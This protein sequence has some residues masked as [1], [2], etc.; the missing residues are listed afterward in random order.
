MTLGAIAAFAV[1]SETSFALSNPAAILLFVVVFSALQ[2][3]LAWGLVSAAVAS[4]YFAIFYS[5]DGQPFRYA[6]AD[7]EDALVWGFAT[8]GIAGMVGLLKRRLER[9]QATQ[10]RI[11]AI[12]I[13]SESFQTTVFQLLETLCESMRWDVGMLWT[14]E[15]GGKHLVNSGIWCRRSL[16]AEAF[17]Q[18]SRERRFAHGE[19]LPGAAWE[20]G[21]PYWIL[22]VTSHPNFPRASDARRAGLHAGVAFPIK[23][24]GELVAVVECFSRHYRGSA[25][26]LLAL[27]ESVGQQI[28]QFLRRKTAEDDLQR[29]LVEQD[30]TIAQ[31]TRDLSIAN[32]QLIGEVA[33]R[34]SVERQLSFSQKQL[35]LIM[36]SI[37]ALI[38]Y[39]DAGLRYVVVNKAYER[40]FDRSADQIIGRH[41][42]EVLGEATYRLVLP[43]VE[44]VL[45]GVAVDYEM[46]IPYLD[47][48]TRHVVVSYVPDVEQDGKVRGFMTLVTDISAVKKARDAARFLADASKALASSLDYGQTLANVAQLA[49]PSF[50][51][52]CVVHLPDADGRL[53]QIAAAHVDPAKV[54]LVRELDH[55]FPLRQ[56]APHGAAHVYRTGRSDLVRAIVPSQFQKHCASQESW[57]LLSTLGLQSYICAPLAIDDRILGT[58]TFAWAQDLRSYDD[59]DLAAAEELAR[60]AALAIEHARVYK[61]LEAANRAKDAW[62]AAVSH[63]LRTPMNVI[64]GW[65]GMLSSGVVDA[66][67]TAEVYRILHRNVRAQNQLIDD[68]LDISRV[69]SG[70]MQIDKQ[71]VEL[72]DLVRDVLESLRLAAE[73]RRI[74]L[75]LV[76]EAPLEPVLGDSDRLR[77]VVFNLVSNGIKFSDAGGRVDVVLR[78]SPRSQVEIAVTDAGIGIEPD[79]LPYVFDRLRQE[80]SRMTRKYGGLG[81]GLAISRHIVEMHGGV[82]EAASEGK[83]RGA[84]FVVRLPTAAG[85]AARQTGPA[86]LASPGASLEA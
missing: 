68:L 23:V 70:K 66:S 46:T 49:I 76:V 41:V 38:S 82:I 37:P 86:L 63:E 21:E 13:E 16:R 18:V 28:G 39:T 77:Q 50:A 65:I 6:P 58:M 72:G 54:E 10:L 26:G 44:K 5:R 61:D 73:A 1:L 7:L 2:G 67:E 36:D 74:E 24:G 25:P 60:R 32:E 8:F 57:A 78:K 64:G 14:P 48:R 33:E 69:I 15:N 85:V 55:C 56:G 3:G 4:L 19:G 84:R 20:K 71:L 12:L 17:L 79:F 22:D 59:D 62:I 81:L 43:W 52:W 35:Q 45:S 47:G 42:L 9:L 75:S 29:V 30:A 80:D 34:R 27:M 11:S 51:D 40:W 83:G 31:R 53:T